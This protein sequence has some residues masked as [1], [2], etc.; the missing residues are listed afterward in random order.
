MVGLL[1]FI[2]LPLRDILSFSPDCVALFWSDRA[3]GKIWE[4]LLFARAALINLHDMS[5]STYLLTVPPCP[6]QQ[7]ALTPASPQTSYQPVTWEGEV[8]P[9]IDQ[10]AKL[11]KQGKGVVVGRVNGILKD[12][13]ETVEPGDHLELLMV[14]HP[15]GLEV[16]RH[17]CA[18]LLAH[19]LSQLWPD[20]Q[21]AIGP[22]I[23]DGFYYDIKMEHRLTP[24]DLPKIDKRMRQ[25]A[26]RNYPVHRQVVTAQQALADFSEQP[27]K[28]E[29]VDEIPQGEVIALYRHEEYTDMCRGPHVTNTRHLKA[30]ALTHLAGAY[31]RGDSNKEML[32]RIYGTAFASQ[33]QLQAHMDRRKEAEKRD[34]RRLGRQMDLFHLRPE[35]PGMVFWHANGLSLYRQIEEYMRERVLSAGY[36]EVRTPQ[37]LEMSLW[38][39]SGHADKFGNQHMFLTGDRERQF[40]LKPMNC[41][42]HIQIYNCGLRSY[43]DLPIRYTEFGS[44]HRNEPSGTLHGLM[45]VRNFVQ[46]DGHVFCTPQQIRGEMEAF[47]ELVDAV[48]ADFGF[49]DIRIFLSTRPAQSVG[50]DEQWQRAEQALQQALES[51]GVSYD[52]NPGEGAFYGPK[53]EFVLK[54]SMGRSWQ[55]GTVQLD[56]TLPERLDVYY[57]DSNDEKQ[58]PV[59]IHRAVLGSLERF[60]GMLIEE[61]HGWL[62][63]WLAPQQAAVIPVSEQ[64][65]KYAQK[66]H[67]QL[68]DAG[69]RSRLD[70]RNEK[71]GYKIRNSILE[72]IATLVLVGDREVERENISLRCQDKDIGQ[73]PIVDYLGQMTRSIESKA[74]Q[75]PWLESLF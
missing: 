1:L 61:Y 11:A 4:N 32:Q 70:D 27:F 41:P 45:R 29:I 51:R 16:V 37:V 24:E 59:M 46:D 48:Y 74:V 13:S 10:I 5:K 8:A 31:W 75:L 49:Q 54:D 67:Q 73:M 71:V 55:C 60:I 43:R 28:Q 39:R 33:E 30:F 64:H 57:T 34:H 36:E 62:P 7:G 40:A 12:S 20:A 38:E 18:H 69:I 47:F 65:A 42:G 9:T 23:E 56:F 21:M 63:L 66:V 22:T 72:R 14:D 6:S 3:W 53:L 58:H 50:S 26:K 17:S 52:I 25:L 2:G 19:A 35:S 44:C 15:E 68:L